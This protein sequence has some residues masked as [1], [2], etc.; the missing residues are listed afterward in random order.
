MREMRDADF[1]H[2]V[3]HAEH[4]FAIEEQSAQALVK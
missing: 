3:E 4:L 2:L 1:R